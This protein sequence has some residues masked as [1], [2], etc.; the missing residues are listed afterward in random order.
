LDRPRGDHEAHRVGAHGRDEDAA[1]RSAAGARRRRARPAPGRR[2]QGRDRARGEPARRARL[3]A[4][5][6]GVPAEMSAM[7]VVTRRHGM[8]GL[9]GLAAAGL[10]PR[11]ALAA[12]PTERRTVVILLRGAL[13][14]L[15][16]VPPYGDPHYAGQ[17]GAIALAKDDVIALDDTFGLNPGLAPLKPL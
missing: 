14:G 15:A 12:V 17:R 9:I 6:P 5:Q 2:D 1:G 4:G 11:L 7:P 8:Q 10:M 13:D 16:A 3:L